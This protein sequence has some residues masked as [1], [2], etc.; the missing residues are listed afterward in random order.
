[1]AEILPIRRK[2]PLNHK[3]S[4]Q[5]QKL[6]H[7]TE[8][9]FRLF[10]FCLK[11]LTTIELCVSSYGDIVFSGEDLKLIEEKGFFRNIS[12]AASGLSFVFSSYGFFVCLFVVL[13]PTQEI[14]TQMETSPLQMKGFKF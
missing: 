5:I 11:S 10:V 2:T 1:M 3:A 4:S 6:Q 7:E 14:F 8:D 9:L 13:S 12:V